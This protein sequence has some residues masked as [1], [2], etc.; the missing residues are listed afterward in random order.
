MSSKDWRPPSL[1]Q[2]FDA[3]DGYQGEFGWVC[4][5]SADAAFMDDAAERFTRLTAAQRAHQGL[6][7]LALYLDPSNPQVRLQDAPGTA[8]L[9]L[10]DLAH[11]RFRLL[12]AK[13]ALLGFRHPEQ[14][15]R[16]RLRLL[17]STGNWTRQTLEESL[18][19]AW[20]IEIASEELSGGHRIGQG[21]ADIQAAWSLFQWLDTLFDTRL[22]EAGNDVGARFSRDRVKSWINQCKPHAGGV[23]RL[24]DN[25]RK[26]LFEEVKQR[27]SVSA[28]ARNY[29]AMGSGFYEANPDGQAPSPDKIV[30]DLVPEKIVKDLIDMRILTKSAD[31]DLFVNPSA[32]QVIANSV[33]RLE[34][35]APS[36]IVRPAVAPEIVFKKAASN[37]NLHAKFLLGANWRDGS[38]ACSS[39]WIY[40][41][42]GNLTNAG[43]LQPASQIRGNLEVGVVFFPEE[44]YWERHRSVSEAHVVTNLLPILQTDFSENNRPESGDKWVPPEA[45]FLSTPVSHLKWHPADDGGELSAPD[46]G[47]AEIDVIAPQGETCKRTETGF[48][49]PGSQ[50][51]SV[52]IRWKDNDRTCEADVP[53]VDEYGRIAATTLTAIDLDEAW[54]Q[55]ADFPLPPESELDGEENH[56]DGEGQA[57]MGLSGIG[58]ATTHR[59]PIRQMMQLIENIAARQTEIEKADWALWCTRLE[60]TLGQAKESRTIREFASLGLNPLSPLWIA[61]FRPIY[62]E[63][64][65]SPEGALYEQILGRLESAWN[66]NDLSRIEGLP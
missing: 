48:L 37:R 36:I 22:L 20:R 4:G 50:P 2:H 24:F 65:T 35:H 12:H 39:T 1:A 5:F 26:P 34:E 60:Q 59:T 14:P 28:V 16:W 64:S 21:C 45:V 52:I 44:V 63:T 56:A 62:A 31:V 41:G 57:L 10:R 42:S 38:N 55:L 8:H 9:P 30:K 58:V 54:W 19:L 18:D 47:N 49:W 15:A 7:T 29:L 66:V 25:R 23:A 40:L 3:P 33:K 61:H 11:K 13:V 51:R 43:F 46:L 6:I 17:V 32:C 27:L 53:V